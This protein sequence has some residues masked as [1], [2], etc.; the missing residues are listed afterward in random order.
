MV[1]STISL[2]LLLIVSTAVSSADELECFN[3]PCYTDLYLKLEEALV[4]NFIVLGRVRAGFISNMNYH[5]FVVSV[6][7]MNGSNYNDDIL[8]NSCN[9]QEFFCSLSDYQNNV[10]HKEYDLYYHTVASR[11]IISWISI[12]HS[13]LLSLTTFFN[14]INSGYNIYPVNITLE[15]ELDYTPSLKTLNCS[16]SE[17]FSWV[18]I[19]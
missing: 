8:H 13:S 3:D 6:N 10:C 17:L 4:S 7:I 15:I 5:W 14:L 12:V 1:S 16:L 9:E 11:G 19:I 2:C 18:S